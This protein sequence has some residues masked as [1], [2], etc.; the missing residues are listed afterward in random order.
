MRGQLDSKSKTCT[1]RMAVDAVGISV[2]VTESYPGRS[3]SLSEKKKWTTCIE[4]CGEGMSE[5]SRG[6]SRLSRP[7]R[8][9]E[10][11]KQDRS[12]NFDDKGAAEKKGWEARAKSGR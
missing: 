11:E 12:L 7:S 2:K 3:G 10:H 6:H 9:P 5:V 1:E 4:R 8:R